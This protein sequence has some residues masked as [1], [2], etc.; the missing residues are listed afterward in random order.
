MYVFDRYVVSFVLKYPIRILQ[1][2]SYVG[3]ISLIPRW[4]PAAVQPCGATQQ[5]HRGKEM[6]RVSRDDWNCEGGWTS[7]RCV[8]S[9]TFGA[10]ELSLFVTWHRMG[11]LWWHGSGSPYHT[12]SGP[13]L[14]WCCS[15]S[16]LQTGRKGF[17]YIKSKI[18]LNALYFLNDFSIQMLY[19]KS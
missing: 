3:V 11:H 2:T 13:A 1:T 18:C 4:E 17:P 19:V 12:A 7:R 5:N 16:L 8:L 6:K 9:Q 10:R 15:P 14:A